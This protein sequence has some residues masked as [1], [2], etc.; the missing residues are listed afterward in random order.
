[1]EFLYKKAGFHPVFVNE[2]LLQFLRYWNSHSSRVQRVKHKLIS[3]HFNL[4]CNVPVSK[5]EELII[6]LDTGQ[7]PS[8]NPSQGGAHTI[9]PRC[10]PLAACGLLILVVRNNGAGSPLI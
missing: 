2:N 3:A 5:S 8:E 10:H 1:M 7:A 9:K 6:S 4:I